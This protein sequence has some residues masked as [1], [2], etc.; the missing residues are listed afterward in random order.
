MF[1]HRT[2]RIHYQHKR[3]W[4]SS[5]G[6]S[7]W[8]VVWSLYVSMVTCLK[9]RG[10]S[11][12]SNNGVREGP[13]LPELS[14]NRP[15][16]HLWTSL[17]I[18]AEPLLRM[19]LHFP[20]SCRRDQGRNSKAP[21][22]SRSWASATVLLATLFWLRRWHKVFYKVNK[23]SILVALLCS[24]WS[25]AAEVSANNNSSFPKWGFLYRPYIS[26]ISGCCTSDKNILHLSAAGGQA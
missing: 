15:V 11:R 2:K 18:T 24:C 12:L 17:A 25:C 21:K 7:E 9:S 10:V 6:I 16:N 13:D 26:N 1:Q 22:T 20:R 4:H 14:Q 3:W 8:L 23:I 19:L 5:G